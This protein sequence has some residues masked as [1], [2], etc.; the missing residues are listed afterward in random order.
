MLAGE[1]AVQRDHKSGLA[2]AVV[3]RFAAVRLI[4]RSL[5]KGRL[6]ERLLRYARRCSWCTDT[7]QK[8]HAAPCLQPSLVCWNLHGLQ[9]SGCNLLPGLGSELTPWTC[10][11]PGCRKFSSRSSSVTHPSP[12]LTSMDSSYYN[13]MFDTASYHMRADSQLK[14]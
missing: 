3:S 12:K 8:V 14:G 1:L 9:A 5:G 6:D 11:S 7:W 13:A 10:L 4:W 2:A